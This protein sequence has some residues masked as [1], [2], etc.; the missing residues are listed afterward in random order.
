MTIK[1]SYEAAEVLRKEASSLNEAK[2]FSEFSSEALSN[3]FIKQVLNIE[4]VCVLKIYSLTII[5]LK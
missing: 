4:N 2:R 1:Y 5:I 3:F